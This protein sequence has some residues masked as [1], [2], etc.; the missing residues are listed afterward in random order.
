MGCWYEMSFLPLSKNRHSS[1]GARFTIRSPR[2]MP[3]SWT[4]A[5]H[6]PSGA[7]GSSGVRLELAPEPVVQRLER[8]VRVV[9]LDPV[10]PEQALERLDP[11]A[12]AGHHPLE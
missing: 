6:W 9:E 3:M 8:V 10:R 1:P 12:L 7:P 2:Y 4:T 11:L 5:N